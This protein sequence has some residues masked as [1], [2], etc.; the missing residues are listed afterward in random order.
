MMKEEKKALVQ[1]CPIDPNLLNKIFVNT[2]YSKYSFNT[3]VLRM[4]LK[5]PIFGGHHL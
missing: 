2:S 3:R 4:I 1:I 5:T